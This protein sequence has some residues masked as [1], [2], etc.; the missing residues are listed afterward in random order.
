MNLEWPRVRRLLAN[1]HAIII[2]FTLLYRDVPAVTRDSSTRY[3]VITH[4]MGNVILPWYKHINCKSWSLFKNEN[5]HRHGTITTSYTLCTSKVVP[6]TGLLLHQ[7]FENFLFIELL[8]IVWSETSTEKELS[9]PQFR[10]LEFQNFFALLDF[11][12]LTASVSRLSPRYLFRY[13]LSFFS[14]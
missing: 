10:L 4:Y 7:K 6:L 5:S 11:A 3:P 8:I 13:G 1:L 14:R 12:N 2:C 9:A